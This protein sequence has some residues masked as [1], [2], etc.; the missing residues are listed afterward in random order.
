[1]LSQ[2]SK[3]A[4]FLSATVALAGGIAFALLREK[5][6]D[7]VARIIAE[8]G[9]LHELDA[10]ASQAN[11]RYVSPGLARSDLDF[12]YD[13]IPKFNAELVRMSKTGTEENMALAVRMLDSL[14]ATLGCPDERRL[15]I[16]RQYVYRGQDAQLLKGMSWRLAHTIGDNHEVL[17]PVILRTLY[18]DE[19]R[20]WGVLTS[21][22]DRAHFGLPGGI[23]SFLQHL[24]SDDASLRYGAA[25]AL[26]LCFA[27]DRP[28]LVSDLLGS[29]SVEMRGCVCIGLTL[30]GGDMLGNVVALS[31]SRDPSLRAWAKAKLEGHITGTAWPPV[32]SGVPNA[33]PV[34]ESLRNPVP[35][36]SDE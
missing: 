21:A 17:V 27:E 29:P 25:L 6:T 10:R 26:G 5:P 11:K 19:G 18:C 8:C 1:M 7:R 4:L 22:I 2:R 32:T 36:S 30:S 9:R 24:R 35:P 15:D 23:D 13:N 28:R 14:R 12:L 3:V 34:E 31:E 33:Q 20:R 16:L